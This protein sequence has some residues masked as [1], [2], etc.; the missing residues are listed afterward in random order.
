MR[1]RRTFRWCRLLIIKVQIIC[2]LQAVLAEKA[3]LSKTLDTRDQQLIRKEFKQLL[4]A[5]FVK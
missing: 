1:I 2:Q 4:E 3:T 5:A